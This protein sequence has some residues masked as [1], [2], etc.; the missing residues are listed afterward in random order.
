MTDYSEYCEEEYDD[1]VLGVV[2]VADAAETTTTAD[3][4]GMTAVA[5]AV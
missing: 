2:P 4:A 1:A 3:D 5:G